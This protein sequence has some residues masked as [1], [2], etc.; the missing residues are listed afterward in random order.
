MKSILVYILFLLLFFISMISFAQVD[1]INAIRAK[2]NLPPLESSVK[3]KISAGIWL[4][5]IVR[6][7]K[8]LAH[9]FDTKYAEIL[10]NSEN[11]VESWMGSTPHRRILLSRKFKKIGISKKN[12]VVCARLN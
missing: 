9:D 1:E 3:L 4:S 8:G 2:H 11:P 7:N 5:H 12:G 10:T 6:H